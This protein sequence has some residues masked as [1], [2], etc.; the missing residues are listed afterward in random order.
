MLLLFT[1][2]AAIGTYLYVTYAANEKNKQIEARI[3]ELTKDSLQ[4][5]HSNDS[6]QT[7]NKNS[8]PID[9]ADRTDFIL[10]SVAKAITDSIQHRD[11]SIIKAMAAQPHDATNFMMID[12]TGNVQALSSQ[13]KIADS[14]NR[15][16][17]G[18]ILSLQRQLDDYKTQL[19]NAQQNFERLQKEF[20][21]YRLKYPVEFIPTP[22]KPIVPDENSLVLNLNFGSTKLS[23]V[24][25]PKD[26]TIYMMPTKGNAKLISDIS[27]YEIHCDE[28]QLRKAVGRKT[29]LFYN[30]KY[31]F[32]DVA[33]GNYFIKV[34]SYYGNYKFIGKG[35]WKKEI[36]MEVS[37]PVQ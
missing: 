32:P 1:L 9:S 18:I 14:V 21:D 34:C 19:A 27:V 4:L 26:M 25:V 33:P 30:G 6:L 31:F 12:N 16:L 8:V 2:L 5:K 13:L 35:N 20:Y 37:P 29:A 28:I 7:A 10:K 23:P 36:T 24:S 15:S 22:P 17:N 11:D 3:E